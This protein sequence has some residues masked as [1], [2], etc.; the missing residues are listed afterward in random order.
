[1]KIAVL[2]ATGPTGQQVVQQALAKGYEVR[3]LVRDPDKMAA[4]VQHEKLQIHKIDL[5]KAE[6][7]IGP[8]TGTDTVLSSLGAR[9][10]IW[11]P[12]SL[13]TDTMPVILAAMR[14]AGVKRLV[15]VT[16]WGSK[17]EAGLPWVIS[18]FLKP[19]FL[20]N[21][22][23]DMSQME[24][25]IAENSGDITYTVVKP[26]GLNNQPVSEKEILTREGQYVADAPASLSRA[27]VAR[28]MLG[29]LTTDTFHNKMVAVAVSK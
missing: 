16:S 20:R 8:M 25:Y 9:G 19:T 21:V 1:M 10:G 23:A 11:T 15:C 3:A 22:L 7:L 18:W 14:Q 28:F 4:Q 5:T 26:P 27:D 24:D 2:G 29:L 12:C 13:Y 6:D 17:D